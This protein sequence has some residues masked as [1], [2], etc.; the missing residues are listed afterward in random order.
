MSLKA[1]L[2]SSVAAFMLVIALLV[3]GVLAASQV[4][5]NM[6][7][8]IS[9]TATDVHAKVEITVAGTADETQPSK[10]YIFSYNSEEEVTTEELVTGDSATWDA[11][12]WTFGAGRQI[13][14]TVKITN[15]DNKR[16]IDVTFVAPED[17]TSD[18][19]LGTNLSCATTGEDSKTIGVSGV[20]TYTMVFTITDENT[21]VNG[22]NW[23]A[24]LTLTDGG[25]PA[26]A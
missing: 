7:G 6:G 14:V 4:T 26:G 3:V 25:V 18:K 20:Y 9:F 13:T 1:K 2:V 15:L 12:S 10:T 17:Q 11:N 22:A 16:E 21:A 24:T 23:D 5:V 8:S 19:A